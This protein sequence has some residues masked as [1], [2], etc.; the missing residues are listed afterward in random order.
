MIDG[1]NSLTQAG[2]LCQRAAQMAGTGQMAHI[3]TKMLAHGEKLI[4]LQM[5]KTLL[6]NTRVFEGNVKNVVVALIMVL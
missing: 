6:I 2:R 3:P 4:A 1:G 5:S